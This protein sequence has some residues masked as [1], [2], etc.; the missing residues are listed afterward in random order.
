MSQAYQET[1]RF[2]S[3]PQPQKKDLNSR[4]ITIASAGIGTIA[5]IGFMISRG[6]Q[7][8]LPQPAQQQFPT[9]SPQNSAD[10]MQE[11]FDPLNGDE[12]GNTEVE[13]ENSIKPKPLFTPNSDED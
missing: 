13:Q 10:T 4:Q 6:K 12:S 3:K 8:D 2:M 5:L 7:T 1:R 11:F 9:Q